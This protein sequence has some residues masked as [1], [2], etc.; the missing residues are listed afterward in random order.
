MVVIFMCNQRL[1]RLSEAIAGRRTDS[2]E[3]PVEDLSLMLV[4]A[5]L[6]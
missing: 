6:A 3:L 5:V 1:S 4:D 2:P